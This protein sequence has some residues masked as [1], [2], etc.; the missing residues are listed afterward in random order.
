MSISFIIFLVLVISGM[1]LSV[2]FKKLTIPAAITGG[3]LSLL[4]Y[5]CSGFAGI[6]MMGVFFITGV[7]ATSFKMERKRKEGLAEAHKGQRTAGQ[8]FANAGIAGIIG[9]LTYF[10]P[11]LASKAPFLV[12]AAFA[13]ATSDTVSSE[14]GNVYGKHFYNITSLKR[15]VKGKNGVISLEGSLFGIAG[16]AVIALI[17]CCFSGFG[18]SFFII[19]VSGIAG[20]IADSFLGATLE[21]KGLLKNNTVNFL[22]TLTAAL[23]AW[24]I[25][26]V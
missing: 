19:A 9:L 6:A 2:R 26:I 3:L 7:M 20:N 10:F 16:S 18:K 14:L 22:N 8:V 5:Y 11:G 15:S 17:F 12:A 21:E 13:S 24:I 25:W 1:F 4:I 23:T